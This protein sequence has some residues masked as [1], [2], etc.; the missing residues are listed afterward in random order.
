MTIG[1]DPMTRTCLMSVRAGIRLRASS[2][3][4]VRLCSGSD[5]SAT[6]RSKSDWAS[7]GPAAA[8][9]WNCTEKAGTSRHSNPSTTSSFRQTKPTWARPNSVSTTVV[10]RCVDGKSVVVGGD[11]HPTCRLLPHRLVDPA[12]P[13]LEL[14]G[15]ETQCPAED[16]V[17]EADSEQRN[18]AT[19]GSA[20]SARPS[21]PGWTDPLDRWT[22][23]RR[24]HRAP[25]SPRYSRRPA[26]RG[27]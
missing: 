3:W 27:W 10:Q 5:I 6:N 23:T 19:A 11:Q 2:G 21:R 22:G 15:A 18:S 1:P 17:S 14:V 13:E 9:G 20:A 24:R 26:P 8:S 4:W 7:C 16:L 25:R 12:V